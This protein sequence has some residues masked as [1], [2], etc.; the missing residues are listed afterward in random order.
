[1]GDVIYHAFNADSPCSV[2]FGED[3][4]SQVRPVS[5]SAFVL[6]EAKKQNLSVAL[7]VGTYADGELCGIS[8]TSNVA[9]NILLLERM[10]KHLLE[11]GFND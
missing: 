11:H 1:M 7:V 8:T 6:D 10:K 4:T 5:N 2:E 9:D 3:D